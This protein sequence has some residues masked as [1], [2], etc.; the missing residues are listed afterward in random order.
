MR[1]NTDEAFR[2]NKRTLFPVCCWLIFESG[3]IYITNSQ[4]EHTE[5]SGRR[6]LHSKSTTPMTSTCSAG[7]TGMWTITKCSGYN[8]IDTKTREDDQEE[9]ELDQTE[10]KPRKWAFPCPLSPPSTSEMSRSFWKLILIGYQMW[11]SSFKGSCLRGTC[12][13]TY[14]QHQTSC[15]AFWN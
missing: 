5:S 9:G 7:W 13:G 6:A 2:L 14:R 11:G 10:D 3:F 8:I 12:P 15:D 4:A 1:K